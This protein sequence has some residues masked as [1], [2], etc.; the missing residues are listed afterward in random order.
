MS[1]LFEERFSIQTALEE[2]LPPA[3]AVD[4]EDKSAPKFPELIGPRAERYLNE[5]D[6][7]LQE[8]DWDVVNPDPESVFKIAYELAEVVD[9]Y[10][11]QE[12]SPEPPVAQLIHGGQRTVTTAALHAAM[13]LETQTAPAE[14]VAGPKKEAI[15][16]S[17]RFLRE[18]HNV[19]RSKIAAM[20]RAVVWLYVQEAE[21]FVVDGVDL[22][23]ED[24]REWSNQTPP[25]VD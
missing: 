12:M 21:E 16:F 1:S 14:M 20:S 2:F 18:R 13:F 24:I 4:G 22:T 5:S 9:E 23:I 10:R 7:Y 25:S 11:R 15:P 19:Q 8:P 17:T 6:S 3:E